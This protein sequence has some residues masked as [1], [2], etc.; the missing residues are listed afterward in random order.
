MK[1]YRIDENT[2][3]KFE[4]EVLLK[5]NNYCQG[6]EM[7]ES[8]G[9]LLGKIKSDFSEYIITDISEPCEKDKCGRCYFLRNKENAQNI[10]N[11]YWKTSGGEIMYLGEWHTHPETYPSPSFVDKSLIKKCSNEIENLQPYI[12][13]VI[14]GDSGSLYVGAKRT[15]KKNNKLLEI[16]EV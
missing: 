3:I 12:F 14:V 9:I 16:F 1:S 2:V 5:F 7:N 11:H 10:I 15:A 8:G 4:D 13:M 6:K